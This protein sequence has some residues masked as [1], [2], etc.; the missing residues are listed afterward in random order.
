MYCFVRLLQRLQ[1]RAR[2]FETVAVV[3]ENVAVAAAPFVGLW[4]LR[5][6]CSTGC[7]FVMLY[8]RW[9]VLLLWLQRSYHLL[10]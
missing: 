1:R 10:C 8:Q 3:A 9:L 7:S 2:L 6:G 4:D 5:C